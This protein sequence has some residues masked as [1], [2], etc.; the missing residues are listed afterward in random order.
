MKKRT[1]N[2]LFMISSLDGKIST[3]ATDERDVDKDF[4][5]IK[6]LKEGIKQYYDL[7]K[8][9]DI[10]SFNTGRVME[11]IGVNTNH[12]PINVPSCNFVIVDN[13]HLT[14]RGV[15]N[16]VNGLRGLYLV[17]TNKNHPAFIIND[18]KL[19]VIFYN[20]KINFVDLFYKLRNQYGAKR[21]TIQSGGTLNSILIREG[22]IDRISLVIS[23]ALIG[24]KDTPSLV[25]GESLK[26]LNDLKKIKTLKFLKIN[27]LKES[28][29]HLV[30]EVEN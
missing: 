7:E 9:T 21:V 28:F 15:K 27:K 16:L 3:G 22:L 11:K 2:T 23:P 4:S 10:F 30:Y 20:K 25:D 13:H 14:E 5:K 1:F 29:I 8:R 24:G 6:G 26:T 18:M 19:K 17:T 12:S